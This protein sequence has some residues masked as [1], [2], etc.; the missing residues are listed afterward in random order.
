MKKWMDNGSRNHPTAMV[1]GQGL[2]HAHVNAV[3]G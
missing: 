2:V 3:K 1:L